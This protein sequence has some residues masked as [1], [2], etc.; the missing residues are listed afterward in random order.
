[1]RNLFA[2]L[3]FVSV[4]MLI[5]PA[6]VAANLG[7]V[8]GLAVFTIGAKAVCTLLAIL[9]FRL[10]ARTTLVA[11]LGMV[12]VGEFSYVLAQ[13]GREAG[14]IPESLH[15]AILAA[16]VLTIVVTPLGFSLRPVDSGLPG[17]WGRRRQSA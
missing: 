7:L 10:G 11:S 9:P 14:A 5:D 12:P 16:S 1:M 6:F 8:L 3:F 2:T 13:T 17:W 4:G 15:A